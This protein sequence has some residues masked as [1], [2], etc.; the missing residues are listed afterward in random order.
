MADEVSLGCY[1]RQYSSDHLPRNPGQNVQELTIGFRMLD[2]EMRPSGTKNILIADVQSLIADT[3]E[4]QKIGAVG[5]V[6]KNGLV[7]DV[8][9]PHP[10]HPD[11]HEDG[12]I[13]CAVECDGGYFQIISQT[14]DGLVIRT[15][16]IRLTDIGGCGGRVYIRDDA[17]GPTTYKLFPAP[18]AVCEAR[19]AE[20]D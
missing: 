15:D 8:S 1:S 19:T 16:G 3:A 10:S 13:T 2:V 17:T 5:E 9:P 11:W 20:G 4:M 14:E 6:Y 18:E 12:A 7:C